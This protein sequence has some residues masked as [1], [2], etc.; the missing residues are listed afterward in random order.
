MC[1]GDKGSL[2]R[3]PQV[4]NSLLTAYSR[5]IGPDFV[6]GTRVWAVIQA[7]LARIP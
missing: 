5:F 2:L 3:I 1:E 7:Q 4:F 6:L